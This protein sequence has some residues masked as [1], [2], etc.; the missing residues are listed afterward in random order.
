MGGNSQVVW[1]GMPERVKA[2]SIAR[3]TVCGWFIVHGVELLGTAARLAGVSL[4]QP[5][6]DTDPIAQK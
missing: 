6:M 1:K 5:D 3:P 4:Q 2:P